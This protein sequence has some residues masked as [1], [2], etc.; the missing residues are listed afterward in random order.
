MMLETRIVYRSNIVNIHFSCNFPQANAARN[1]ESQHNMSASL[2]KHSGILIVTMDDVTR[3]DSAVTI[4]VPHQESKKGSIRSSTQIM[5]TC[6]SAL[7]E[8]FDQTRD[9]IIIKENDIIILA[10]RCRP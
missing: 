9:S 8:F 4:P 10:S 7:A 2:D 5:R 6:Q 1:K 3:L